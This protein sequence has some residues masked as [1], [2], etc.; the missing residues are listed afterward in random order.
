M[1]PASLAQSL[2]PR[3]RRLSDLAANL[4]WSWYPEAVELFS[5][6]DAELW[7][8]SVSTG[9]PNPVTLLHDVAPQRLRRLARDPD[10]L[11]RYDAV[12]R[13][14]DATLSASPYPAPEFRQAPVAYFSAEFGLHSSLPIYSGGLGVLAGDHCKEA[15][16]LGLP[17]VG[18]GLLYGQGYFHQRLSPDGRQE[19]RYTEL[20]RTTAPLVPVLTPEGTQ[21]QV[22]V[23]IASRDVCLAVWQLRLGRICLYLL[24]SDVEDNAAE[25]RVL[26]ARLYGGD[27]ETR[28]RQEIALGIGGVRALRAVGMAPRVWHLNE[29][30]AALVLVERLRELVGEGCSFD[31]AL[32]QVRASSVFTTHTP[33]PAGH[34]AFP[35]DLVEHCLPAWREELGVDRERFFDL[36]RYGQQADERFHMTVLALRL[37]GQRNA[38]SHIHATVSRRMWRSVWPHTS[39]DQAPIDAVTNGVHVPTWLAP[40]LGRLFAQY[41]G[42]DWLA[43]HDDPQLWRRIAD[44]PD[45]ELWAVHLRLKHEL[46]RFLRERARQRRRGHDRDAMQVLAAGGLL[47]PDVLTIGFAR[48][49]AT[50]K[51]ATLLLDNLARLQTLL[52]ATDRPVQI[53]FA[54]KAHPADE[55][56][57]ALIRQ[58]YAA[59]RDPKLGGRIAFVEDYDMHVAQFLVRGVDV[60]LNNP[61]SPQEACGTSGEKAALNGIPNLSIADGWWNEAHN[62]KNGWIVQPADPELSDAD[63]DAVEAEAFYEL[64]AEEIVPLFYERDAGGIPRG[65]LRVMQAALASI[66]AQFS[67]RRMLKEYIERLYLPAA[68]SA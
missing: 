53:I 38:V 45:E 5:T 39:P 34:D 24:D 29:G 13:A 67:A 18:V 3:I 27:Q 17:L 8:A 37:S 4:W 49:F 66:P 41:L 9:T 25:D 60:W 28:L 64:L 36:A 63:R 22:R 47:D 23:R 68:R 2:P 31:E 40:E 62:G 57:Q 65:W 61:V 58:V 54:G 35:F 30:H 15:S 7:Q 6:I 46:I 33:V 51:R 12:V 19:A 11:G 59:A 56:G 43:S 50:Y 55:P 32:A 20:E 16:D 26:S 44:I 48:R 14:F 21:R 1:S 10:F 42:S 52:G